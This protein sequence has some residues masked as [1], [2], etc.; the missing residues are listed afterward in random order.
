LVAIVQ[1][2]V[3]D[4]D[5]LEVT[6]G[7]CTMNIDSS[8]MRREMRIVGSRS[9]TDRENARK[10]TKRVKALV[11]EAF[12]H[13]GKN[14]LYEEQFIKYFENRGMSKNEVDKLW[15]KAENMKI[16][17]RGLKPIFREKDPLDIL[18]HVVVFRLLGK[19][20]V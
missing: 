10:E 9:G 8:R 18:G 1:A 16:I 4:G 11:E 13:F 7:R 6:W 17:R 3:V 5:S 12:G 20:D 15:F 19:G 14:A 2:Y